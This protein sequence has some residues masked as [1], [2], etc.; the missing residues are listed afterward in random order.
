M[1]GKTLIEKFENAAINH[2]WIGAT[3]PETHEETIRQYKMM[4]RVIMKLIGGRKFN[5]DEL[6]RAGYHK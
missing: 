1:T 4:R 5:P 3:E 2:S 6:V